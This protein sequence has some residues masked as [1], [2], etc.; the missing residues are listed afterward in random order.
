MMTQTSQIDWKSF[1]DFAI[2]YVCRFCVVCGW[3]NKK[4]EAKKRES[5]RIHAYGI[6]KIL[7]QFTK[8]SISIL[9]I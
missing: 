5:N 3:L 1:E 6:F 4:I 8:I 7:Q 9:S 2:L